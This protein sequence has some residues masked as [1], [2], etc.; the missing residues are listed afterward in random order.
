MSYCSLTSDDVKNLVVQG[1]K[2][3]KE[4]RET[5]APGLCPS[6]ERTEELLA[7]G[8]FK[9]EK[10]SLERRL[11]SFY[12]LNYSYFEPPSTITLDSR[13]PFWDKHLDMPDLT[14]TATSYC[15]AHELIHADD[16]LNGIR[17]AEET[18]SHIETEH[19]DKLEASIK[20]LKK[21]AAPD[22]IQKEDNLVRIW[23][24]Q[25]ADMATHYRTYLVFRHKQLPRID[26]IWSALA[27]H[28]FSPTI[29]CQIEKSRGIDYVLDR[30]TKGVGRWCLVD[31]LM[32]ADEACRKSATPYA[33]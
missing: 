22:F 23:A 6:I 26:Y 16:Y 32:E 9:T 4:V 12:P 33:V 30:I 25:Y 10:I 18:A 3:I 2:L 29:L 15:A 31:A 11:N 5:V 13:G 20:L 7:Q 28:F 21:T 27:N 19:R 1:V 8:C 17:I 24:Q 14:K